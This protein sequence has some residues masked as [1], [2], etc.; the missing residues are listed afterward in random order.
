MSDLVATLNGMKENFDSSAAQGLNHVFQFNLTEGEQ[1]Y[2]TIEN[3]ECKVDTGN[4]T[5]P[6]V[7]LDLSMAILIELMNGSLNGVQAFMQGKLKA[8]GNI[9]L[10][11]KLGELFPV[12]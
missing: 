9:M 4:H 6:S 8:T 5:Q 11:A 3:A 7:T 12:Q 10:A 2:L 1:F